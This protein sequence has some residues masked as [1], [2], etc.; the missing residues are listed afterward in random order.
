MTI[1]SMDIALVGTGSEATAASDKMLQEI[2]VE[3]QP[4]FRRVSSILKGAETRLKITHLIKK[5]V[6]PVC[7]CTDTV[8]SCEYL[9][10]LG[11]S[12]SQKAIV[13]GGDRH[14][15]VLNGRDG[16]NESVFDKPQ[17]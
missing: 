2:P 5:C 4:D 10:K 17:S 8:I 6:H 13:A 11:C 3:E 1:E 12:G 16:T 15:L 7:R 9:A 14:P